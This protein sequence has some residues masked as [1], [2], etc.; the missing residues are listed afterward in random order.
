[1]PRFLASTGLTVSIR[2]SLLAARSWDMSLFTIPVGMKS[3]TIKNLSQIAEAYRCAVIVR[4]HA[5]LDVLE[6]REERGERDRHSAVYYMYPPLPTESPLLSQS[7][8]YSPVGW[9]SHSR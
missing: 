1:M 6:E 8:L 4:T 3:P 5:G 7:P 2:S 9:N